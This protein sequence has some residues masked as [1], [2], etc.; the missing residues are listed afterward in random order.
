MKENAGQVYSSSGE[1]LD[2]HTPADP[3]S[4]RALSVTNANAVPTGSATWGSAPR[5]GETE[6]VEKPNAHIPKVTRPSAKLN[7]RFLQR[8][9]EE[10][11]KYLAQQQEAEAKVEA[12]KFAEELPA[13][14]KRQ[15]AVIARMEKK[16]KALEKQLKETEQQ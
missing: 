1:R 10:A 14:A 7:D 8:D 3:N 16:I 5:I 13:W 11:A 12:A 2:V 6:K 9:K 4:G 15:D